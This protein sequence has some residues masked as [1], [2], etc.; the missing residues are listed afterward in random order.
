MCRPRR[1]SNVLH[2]QLQH[3]STLL[4]HFR[5]VFNLAGRRVEG[6]SVRLIGCSGL[7]AECC[8]WRK[9]GGS[10]RGRL[11]S[12]EDVLWNNSG[13]RPVPP[14]T[15]LQNCKAARQPMQ[16]LQSLQP[17]IAGRAVAYQVS[18]RPAKLSKP[19]RARKA[20]LRSTVINLGREAK[21]GN[22]GLPQEALIHLA[23]GLHNFPNPRSE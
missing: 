2:G 18:S 16:T 9:G 7:L 21:E 23:P 11:N 1:T 17:P 13:R 14:T 15:C 19:R 10:W 12:L 4:T 3:E 8:T 6:E 22:E 20:T 5:L